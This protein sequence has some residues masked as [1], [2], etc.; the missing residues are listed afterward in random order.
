MIYSSA[1]MSTMTTRKHQIGQR[2][3][4]SHER[5]QCDSGMRRWIDQGTGTRNNL[6]LHISNISADRGPESV[7]ICNIVT[8]AGPLS[9]LT[10]IYLYVIKDCWFRASVNTYLY[11][12]KDCYE[13]LWSGRIH[14]MNVMSSMVINIFQTLTRYLR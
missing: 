4:T 9:T 13:C 6:W 5:K 12:I 3:N 7:I 14:C 2:C 8:D 11:V 1:Y 10:Y